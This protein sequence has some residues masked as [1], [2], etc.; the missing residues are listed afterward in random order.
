[1]RCATGAGFACLACVALEL[2]RVLEE[3]V[4]V[5]ADSVRESVRMMV[6]IAVCGVCAEVR[7]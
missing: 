5:L 3:R 6:A 1:M 7:R 2:S 4:G